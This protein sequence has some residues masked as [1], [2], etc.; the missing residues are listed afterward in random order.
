MTV[1]VSDEPD[2]GERSH[3]GIAGV[4][5]RVV[6]LGRRVDAGVREVAPVLEAELRGGKGYLRIHW[7]LAGLAKSGHVLECGMVAAYRFGPL[8]HLVDG[9]L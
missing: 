6:A 8:V 5:F 2:A 1:G 3:L 4:E 9:G 7:D